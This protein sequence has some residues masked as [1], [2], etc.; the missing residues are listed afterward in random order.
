MEKVRVF[1]ATRWWWWWCGPQQQKGKRLGISHSSYDAELL[2]V[3]AHG[4]SSSWPTK[5]CMHSRITPGQAIR[6]ASQ[7]T[8]STL[9]SS[10]QTKATTKCMHAFRKATLSLHTDC[11]TG[12][13]AARGFPPSPK[14]KGHYP[15]IS[16]QGVSSSRPTE[17]SR[18][19]GIPNGS[20]KALQY[21]YFSPSPAKKG[22]TSL[23][24]AIPASKLPVLCTWCDVF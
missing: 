1:L 3:T 18:G 23:E 21:Q 6:L 16:T 24:H 22:N 17:H 13:A 5:C 11:N 2:C 19:G 15:T 20:A 14:S 8:S 9:V 10:P 12:P 7:A 4:H